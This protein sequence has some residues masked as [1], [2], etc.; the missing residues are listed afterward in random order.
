[1]TGT[2]RRLGGLALIAGCLLVLVVPAATLAHPLGNF[3]INHYS[4]LRVAQDR[5]T[6][7]QVFDLAEIP[8]L[9]ALQPTDGG[10]GPGG[11]DGYARSRCTELASALTMTVDGARQE[12]ALD[13]CGRRAAAR[14][15]RPEHAAP[16]LHLRDQPSRS[17][18]RGRST[19]GF[20]DGTFAE[21]I[22][23]REMVVEADGVTVQ[24][25]DVPK[26]DV[27][28]RL[29]R[30]PG[31]LVSQPLDRSSVAFAVTDGGPRLPPLV[32]TDATPLDRGGAAGGPLTRP[33]TM[34]PEPAAVA[35]VPGGVTELPRQL[36]ELLRSDALTPPL[37]AIGLLVAIG[38]GALHA[39]TPGHGKTI[40]A[41][42]L[43]GTRGD[44]AQAIGLGATVAISH[45]IG[46]LVLAMLVLGASSVLPPERLF[47]ILSG[48]SA[49]LVTAIGAWLLLDAIRR[50]RGHRAH[51]HA[52]ADDEPHAHHDDATAPTNGNPREPRARRD[53]PQ[54]RTAG[55][56]R[57]ADPLARHR[58]PRPGGWADPVGLG[59]PAPVGRCR[60]GA[61]GPRARLGG[62][63]RP[64][65]GG[66][67]RDH[68][69][70][71]GSRTQPGRAI[72]L[73]GT[74]RPARPGHVDGGRDRRPRLRACCSP[75]SRFATLPL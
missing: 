41:A 46:V 70:P 33:S 12:L 24:S 63:L 20:V 4:R 15:G 52:H 3:T 34:L 17:P 56:G 73:A 9:Q 68:R 45:T 23:W 22:G 40:M 10:F 28:A 65:H 49:V 53:P 36:T 57:S 66:C 39:L 13:R 27:S 14:A 26:R 51:A 58:D 31:D 54:P 69:A 25:G 5:I 38:L 61:S 67:P 62:R 7:D 18:S 8:A 1:M 47:P 19:C 64:G 29:T 44:A 2:R 42:Y 74:G 37:I 71:A 43:V 55:G 6:V 35:S 50:I 72:A 21:R 11:A 48:I 60:V 16:R 59:H 75:A 32:V 30:Y